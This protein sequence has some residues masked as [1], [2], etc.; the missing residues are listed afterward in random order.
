[1]YAKKVKAISLL[2]L[3]TLGI[4]AASAQSSTG[5]ERVATAA[6]VIAY[7]SGEG[8]SR[9]SKEHR[10]IA[11]EVSS[12]PR[13]EQKKLVDLVVS[14]DTPQPTR[15]ALVVMSARFTDASDRIR[16]ATAAFDG[17]SS[18][19]KLI[20]LAQLTG[21]ITP[22]SRVPPAIVVIFEKAVKDENNAVSNLA[23]RAVP[24]LG[25]SGRS[26]DVT[27]RDLLLPNSKCT[28]ANR[29]AAIEAVEAISNKADPQ[30][31]AALVKRVK[32]D[33]SI[34][35]FQRAKILAGLGDAAGFEFLIQ[36]LN[37]SDEVVREDAGC[38]LW[39]ATGIDFG[40]SEPMTVS[41]R[42]ENLRKWSEW[43]RVNRDRLAASSR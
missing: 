41:Q 27:L 34:S 40:Y 25:E 5:A 19:M 6:E 9:V 23:I 13:I 24:N 28:T 38:A 15:A 1:V 36:Q 18:A 16:I 33:P 17:G 7:L 20:A 12:I 11:N 42:L 3:L 35:L 37:N 4:E 21:D 39:E 29:L 2:C 31:R 10:N 32:E 8:R 26:L 43:L 14:M 22:G 30:D